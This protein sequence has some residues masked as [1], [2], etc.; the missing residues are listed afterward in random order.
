MRTKYDYLF[1][2]LDGTLTDSGKGIMRSVAHALRFFG[3]EESDDANLKRFVGPPLETS[4]SEFYGLN[5]EETHKAISLYQE[6]YKPIGVYENEPYEGI[7]ECLQ[8]LKDAGYR[9]VV[10]TSKPVDM[11]MKVL[12]HFNLKHYFEFIAA[13]DMK[14]I[15]YSKADV[16]RYALKEHAVED[17]N[18]VLMIGDRKFDVLGAREVGFD[19]VGVLYGYGDLDEMKR[20]NAKYVVGTVDQ[21]KELLLQ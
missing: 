6:R 5:E 8:S 20:A 11:A 7:E 17:I 10:A 1:F 18:R 13:R 2:D 14:G 19:C 3:I 12:E 4:F 16:I 15:L 9:L 21:L